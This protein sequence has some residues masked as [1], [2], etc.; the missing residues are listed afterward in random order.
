MPARSGQPDLFAARGDTSRRPTS[1][2]QLL[3]RFRDVL[4]GRGW[5]AG[6]TLATLL[7]TNL[8]AL[9]DAAH[10]SR[11]LIL[12]GN[13]GYCLAL[14]ASLTDIQAVTRRLYSQSRE[15]RERA[16]E[17]ERVRRGTADD[18]DGAA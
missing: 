11:G 7:D 10:E 9:R 6:A 4:R 2:A 5:V 1:A 3:P 13:R 17:I 15:M 14:E 18:L 12:G 8:R 16:M